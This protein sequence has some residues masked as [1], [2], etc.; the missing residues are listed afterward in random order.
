MTGFLTLLTAWTGLSRSG[1]ALPS[2]PS[3]C[4]MISFETCWATG[5]RIPAMVLVW[6]IGILI[7][8]FWLAT[9]GVKGLLGHTSFYCK[10]PKD[11]P[12]QVNLPLF[13]PFELHVKKLSFSCFL[14]CRQAICSSVCSRVL[15]TLMFRQKWNHW[16]HANSASHAWLWLTI[17]K[18][19]SCRA[20]IFT[21]TYSDLSNKRG[22]LITCR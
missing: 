8:F 18:S 1:I 17:H 20:Y 4:K 21:P 9:L 15:L 11:I 13:P 16:P 22:V 7:V 2:S 3:S 14:T 10:N 19:I 12:N 5:S 6:Y